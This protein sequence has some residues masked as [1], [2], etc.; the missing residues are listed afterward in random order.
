[1]FKVVVSITD[2]I[3]LVASI[4]S[5]KVGVSFGVD[6]GTTA[7]VVQDACIKG[8]VATNIGIKGDKWVAVFVCLTFKGVTNIDTGK[9]TDTGSTAKA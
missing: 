1:M 5:I 3:G 9:L 8:G 4:N 6:T 7:L 2:S